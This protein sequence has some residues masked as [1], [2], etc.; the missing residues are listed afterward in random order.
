[1]IPVYNVFVDISYRKVHMDD[2]DYLLSNGYNVFAESPA[3]LLGNVQYY[4]Y[5]GESKLAHVFDEKGAYTL[6]D[7]IRDEGFI[8]EDK[9]WDC[10]GSRDIYGVPDYVENWWRPEYN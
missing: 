10:I 5:T 3:D 7:R 6:V 8:N 9:Y 1:M 4:V 2:G